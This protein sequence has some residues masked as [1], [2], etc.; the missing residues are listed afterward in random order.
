[1]PVV[2]ADNPLQSVAFGAGQCLEQLAILRDVL[3]TSSR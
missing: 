1:M 2:I 3:M